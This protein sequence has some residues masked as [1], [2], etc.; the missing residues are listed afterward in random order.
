MCTCPSLVNTAK[1]RVWSCVQ[2][3]SYCN[4]SSK[5]ENE[6]MAVL[7]LDEALTCLQKE[8][9]CFKKLEGYYLYVD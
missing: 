4:G 1:Y 2:H 7:S 5:T 6:A 3:T 8:R 9:K